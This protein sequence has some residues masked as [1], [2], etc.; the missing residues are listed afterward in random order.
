MNGK[1]TANGGRGGAELMAQAVLH[2]RGL[3]V[4]GAK[5]I[6]AIADAE[7]AQGKPL[8]SVGGG[9][10]AKGLRAVEDGATRSHGGARESSHDINIDTERPDRVAV[11]MQSHN[12][13]VVE[14]AAISTAATIV[15]P[16]GPPAAACQ[17]VPKALRGSGELRP[18]DDDPLS[19]RDSSG[20]A[21]LWSDKELMQ[22]IEQDV[23][24]TMPD[25][26]FYACR[27]MEDGDSDHDADGDDFKRHDRSESRLIGDHGKQAR[28]GQYRRGRE[29][30]L[31]IARI[32]FVHAKLN[33]AES[34]T[35]GMN[36]IVATLFFVL[37][38]DDEEEWREH[39]EADTFFCFTNLMA[40]IR[41][42]FIQS[43]DESESGLQGKM[44][45]FGRTLRHHDPELAG[46]MVR[47]GQ[48][49]RLLQYVDVLQLR[50]SS[51][52]VTCRD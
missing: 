46:H 16:L 9:A 12:P 32:L 33:P 20:W 44:E 34:Y 40:E 51:L 3:E 42:V 38:T 28:G 4:K 15:V 27:G 21:A 31:A 8:A 2:R 30:R 43:L 18:T 5:I 48:H 29:R 22:A 39:C 17:N 23:I 52:F 36:E 24:R 13:L 1:T 41:D 6:K 49:P 7:S 37:A 45:A 14:N 19:N 50:N 47:A 35:Q 11:E 25:L 10:S 26:A